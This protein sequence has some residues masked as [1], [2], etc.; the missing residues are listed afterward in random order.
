MKQLSLD[1]LDGLVA[2]EFFGVI[3]PYI[4]VEDYVREGGGSN[5]PRHRI[6]IHSNI[7][8]AVVREALD[9]E[10]PC[11]ACG[12]AIHPFRR[13]GPT[14]RGVNVGHLYYAPCCPLNVSVSCSRGRAA[15]DEYR[16]VIAAVQ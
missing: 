6:E 2:S 8:S 14:K 15:S 13:R 3:K 5:N 16:R 11:V 1:M 4:K 9:F 7:P 12:A 10:M